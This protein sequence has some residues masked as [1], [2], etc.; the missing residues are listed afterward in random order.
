MSIA[1]LLVAVPSLVVLAVVL[2]NLAVWPRGRPGGGFNGHVSVL[3]PARDEAETIE[4]C[5]RAALG[6]TRVPDEVLVYDDN[7][8]D[9]TAEIVARLARDDPRLRLLRGGPLPPGWVGKPHACQHLATAAA[10]N[11]LVYLDADTRLEPEGLA[12]LGSVMEGLDAEL[13]SAGTRQEMGTWAERLM[14]PLLSLSYLAWLPLSLVWRSPDPRFLVANGQLLAVKRPALERAGGWSAIRAE[15]VDDMALARRVKQSGAR[16]VFADGFRMAR[17]RM[18]HGPGALW[19]GFSKNLYEGVGGST[20]GLAAVVALYGGVFVAPYVALGLGVAGVGGGTLFGAAALGVA[21]N[22]VIRAVLAWRFRHPVEGMALHPIG[23]LVL[24]AIA[25][26]S[27]RWSRLGAIR[28]RG[29]IYTE[30]ASRIAG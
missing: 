1:L 18:Y 21:A 11:V 9:A 2:S 6:G 27:R 12:R 10:G 24:L 26:N 7:S 16:V 15:V 14:I 23:V 4:A 28:W 20:V 29:R 19:Q 5:V 13:V 8:S 22:V 30:R 3:I 17:C 25:L